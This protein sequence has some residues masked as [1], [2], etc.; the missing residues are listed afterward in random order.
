MGI[1][2]C[3]LNVQKYYESLSLLIL[4]AFCSWCILVACLLV[5]C[6]SVAMHFFLVSQ[7]HGAIFCTRPRCS[8]LFRCI[9]CLPPPPRLILGDML[10]AGL[11][12]IQ[13]LVGLQK[14]FDDER[15]K[16]TRHLN[17]YHV[18]KQ[19]LFDVGDVKCW[20]TGGGGCH[21]TTNNFTCQVRQKIIECQGTPTALVTQH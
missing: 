3:I 16:V 17:V 19:K 20:V 4:C 7:I 1:F 5:S 6:I 13:V 8:V 14:M 9:F 11:P 21:P 12:D 2:G 15:G 10:V 18:G